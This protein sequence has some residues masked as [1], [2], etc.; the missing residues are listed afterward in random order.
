MIELNVVQKIATWAI[1]VL[2]AITLHEVAHGWVAKL[3][4]DRTAMML[5]RLSLNP[6]KHIDPVGTVIVPLLLLFFSPFV[7]GWAKPVPVAWRNLKR[8]KRDMAI[9]ALAGPLANLAMLVAWT[10]VLQLMVFYHALVPWVAE[11]L[12]FMSIAGIVINSIL[13]IFNLIP[14]PPL[15]GGRVLTGLLP[16]PYARWFGKLEPY[17]MFIIVALL[18]TKVLGGLISPAVFWVVLLPVNLNGISPDAYVSILKA[19]GL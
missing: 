13:M 3:L 10:L 8:P 15:D 2:F 9:V 11:P 18:V 14:I 16:M 5:G 17:G 7:L 1:P 6:L 4:G 12:I 19:L